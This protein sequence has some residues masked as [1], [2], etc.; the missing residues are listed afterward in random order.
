MWGEP[1][2]GKADVEIWPLL[3]LTEKMVMIFP[4]VSGILLFLSSFVDCVLLM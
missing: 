1:D 2:I 3:F 4:M